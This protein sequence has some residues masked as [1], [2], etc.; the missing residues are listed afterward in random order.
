MRLPRKDFVAWSLLRVFE[1]YSLDG[2]TFGPVRDMKASAVQE[3]Y[4][5]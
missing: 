3:L 2:G 1:G 5:I 4:L